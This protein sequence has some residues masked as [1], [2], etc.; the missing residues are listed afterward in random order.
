[1]NNKLLILAVIG[2]V[3]Y[4]SSNVI[5]NLSH[6]NSLEGELGTP[7]VTKA[8]A[9]EAA[10]R[11][12]KDRLGITVTDTQ[13][14]Y[15]TDKYASGYA[16]K[17]N[18]QELYDRDFADKALLDYW[19]VIVGGPSGNQEAR[20][21]VGMDQPVIKAWDT[22]TP[23]PRIHN[24]RGQSLAV[25]ALA[26]E[27]YNPAE[28]TYAADQTGKAA[29]L[30]TYTSKTL[31]LGDA[32]LAVTIGI[33]GDTVASFLTH[34]QIPDSYMDWIKSQES[35][36]GKM[37][38]TFL[39]LTA[40]MGIV[41]LIL[42]AVNGRKVRWSRGIALTL[43]FFILYLISNFNA[44]DA[45][46]SVEGV[47]Q[48]ARS[49]TLIIM[50]IFVV[51]IALLMALAVWFSLLSGEQQWRK[52]GSN[53][54]PRWRDR[55][56]GEEVFYGMGRGYLLCFFIMGVQQAAFLVAG[57]AFDSFSI[58]DPAQSTMNMK[59]AFLFPTAAWVAAIMEEAIYRLFGV[60]LF[61]RILR[62]NFPALLITSL[63]WGLGHT[64][65]TIYPSYTRLIEVAL[66]GLIFGYAFLKYGFI[67]VVFAHAI[68]DSLLMA[69]YLMMEEPSAANILWGI[70][71]MVLPVL[72]G[73]VVRYLHPRFGGPK[74]R[75]RDAPP[76]P[77]FPPEPRLIGLE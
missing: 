13:I 16:A 76:A 15:Q 67:T 27:G 26:D 12:A 1:M 74:Q 9:A 25:Q 6:D 58:N 22:E 46:L 38:T 52:L 4:F 62:Y 18:L 59:W 44:A 36:S 17:N 41:A 24:D 32:P 75:R 60:A 70:F 11:F 42:A 53:F 19:L 48:N 69:L 23:L 64:G 8:A 66:L 7:G 51:G 29:N 40:A 47:D 56:F 45:L 54:W 50:N 3:L 71:Y 34:F 73:Y 43:I 5:A 49:L 33:S 10:A 28:W 57:M 68:M 14:V 31:M 2:I 72:I 35:L 39:L 37:S 77:P 30:F 21:R 20:I 61:K 65:Y 63:I 55:E